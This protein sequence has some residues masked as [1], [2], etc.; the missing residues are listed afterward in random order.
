M[1]DTAYFV[2]KDSYEEIKEMLNVA[3]EELDPKLKNNP[4]FMEVLMREVIYVYQKTMSK[5]FKIS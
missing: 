5:D 2:E 1:E 3:K 4:K